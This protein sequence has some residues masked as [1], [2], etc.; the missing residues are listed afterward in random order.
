MPTIPYTAHT[1]IE[2]TT[3]LAG[4]HSDNPYNSTETTHMSP[5]APW[6]DRLITP[7]NA[8]SLET[9][10]PII[11]NDDAVIPLVVGCY[12]L[13]EKSSGNDDPPVADEDKSDRAEATPTRSGELRLLT[14]RNDETLQFEEQLVVHMESGVLDGKWRRVNGNLGRN[15]NKSH[16][17]LFASACASGKI[18]LHSLAHN[19]ITNSWRFDPVSSSDEGGEGDHALCLS[20]AW[21]DCTTDNNDNTSD[22]IV[23]SYSD[24]TL[25]LHEVSYSTDSNDDK[26]MP[27]PTVIRESQRWDAHS[28]FGCPSEV[29]TCSFLRGDANVVMSGADD[30]S[31]KLWDIR[32]TTKPTHKI[33]SE[34]FEAGVTA[35]SSHP[36]V[37]YI[38]A[39]GSYD[40]YV[41]V[42]DSRMTREPLGKVHVGGG[43]WRIKWHPLSGKDEGRGYNKLLVA[44]MHGGC[45]V[46]DCHGFSRQE[47]DGDNRGGISAEIVSSFTAHE[48]M[49]YGADWICFHEP[50]DCREAAASCSFYD[51]QVFLWSPDDFHAKP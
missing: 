49:A 2:Q 32:Q 5:K 31:L 45:R 4:H 18:H 38:F 8:C 48:S 36:A 20:L 47:V 42:Y 21:D 10:S 19:P 13:N 29:W 35:I 44:A 23:S 41:R 25:A 17:A 15:G 12:Q 33:S 7:F 43:V 37:N 3:T 40:E 22:L 46:V 27:Q 16:E 39:A 30:C 11:E 24:G 9:L 51:R 34:E 6:L 28:M 26:G 14:V 1:N 50:S